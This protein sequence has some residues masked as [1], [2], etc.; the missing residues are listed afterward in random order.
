MSHAA[1]YRDHAVQGTDA[2][3]RETLARVFPVSEPFTLTRLLILHLA[4]GVVLTA[5]ILL[6][7]PVLTSWGI[8]PVFALFGGIGL[9]LV[10]LE[11]G[12]LA[13]YARR[14]TGSWS[15]L[16]AVDYRDRL[17]AGRLAMLAGGLVVWFLLGLV[18]SIAFADRRLAQGVFA[19]MPATL[20]QFSVVEQGGDPLTGGALVA[21]LLLALAFNGIAGPITEELYFRGHLLPRLERYGRWA[22]VLNTALFTLYHFFSPWRYPA[23]F[24]GFLP[25]TWMAWRTRS[26][27]VSIAAHMTINTVT[28]LLILAAALAPSSS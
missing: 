12:Y 3:W 17:P 9:I 8:D 27:Y 1:T 23:I 11:L 28:V 13:V 15:P 7:A 20:R 10:P 24:V 6:A 16:R 18:V 25:I 22:P 26:V 2:R 21:L 19:W 5:F 14:T 4:P